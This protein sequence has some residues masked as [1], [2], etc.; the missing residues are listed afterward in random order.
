MSPERA[1]DTWV[2]GGRYRQWQAG[3]LD[4]LDVTGS[5]GAAGTT[6]TLDH[7]PRLKR[8]V[9][10]LEAERPRLHRIR[11]EGVGVT[12]ETLATFEADGSGTKMT[13]SLDVR[14]GRVMAL[15]ARLARRSTIE[16]EFRGSSSG[17]SR[18]PDGRRRK[19]ARVRATPPTR[20]PAGG[21]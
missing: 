12:D 9:T 7:G 5:I 1:Y 13:V 4:V 16:R 8:R 14:Y 20:R 17:S 2:D 3:V 10:V 6:Y 21:S 18:S 11:Q 15:F 19:R